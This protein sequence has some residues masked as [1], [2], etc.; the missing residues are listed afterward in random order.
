L[1]E[2]SRHLESARQRL[3][4]DLELARG[5]QR[6]FLPLRLPE[7]TGYEFA[8][9]Y[10]PAYEV[11]GDYYDFIHL[12]RKQV[13]VLVGDVSGKGVAAALLMAKLSADARVCMLTETD[14]ATAFTRL[15]ALMNKPGI[16]GW[17]VTLVAAILDPVS[18]IVTL[19][20]AGHSSP[21]IYHRA[22]RTAREAITTEMA[23]FPLCV[24]DGFEYT[25]C[26]IHLEP[27]DS[28][29]TFTDGVTDAMNVDDLRLQTK[30]VYAAVQG[31]DYSTDAL[32][33]QVVT[34]V[35]QFTNG[36]KQNDDIT[37]VGFGRI[38]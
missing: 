1:E 32:V 33:E 24:V 10:A 11:G 30:G 38:V 12:P 4:L 5:V 29:L 31:G 14:P 13:A 16:P 35:K 23:G 19:I 22:S 37:L 9:H 6:S 17:F 34:V 3:K 8:A 25:S 7:V 21:L 20:N 15:N 18:H 2:Y 36:R 28:I 26:Q 27:G